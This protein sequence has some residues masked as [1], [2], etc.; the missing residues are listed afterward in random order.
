MKAFCSR[1]PIWV[2]SACVQKCL[3]TTDLKYIFVGLMGPRPSCVKTAPRKSCC[4]VV[5]DYWTG[6]LYMHI[7]QLVWYPSR[8][9]WPLAFKAAL[10]CLVCNPHRLCFRASS[11]EAEVW[12]GKREAEEREKNERE[13]SLHCV[14]EKGTASPNGIH[15]LT[16]V[17][18]FDVSKAPSPSDPSCHWLQSNFCNQTF[19]QLFDCHTA[20]FYVL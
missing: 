2:Y 5:R 3:Q 6:H 12:W 19:W 11:E 13:N 15:V 1:I 4:L 14:R 9:L 16:P 18:W 17:F 10:Y 8:L 20:R 7:Q